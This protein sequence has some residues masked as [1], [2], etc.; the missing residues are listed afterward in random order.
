[1]EKQITEPQCFGKLKKT[2]DLLK[3]EKTLM[4]SKKRM[5]KQVAEPQCFGKLTKTQ[6]LLKI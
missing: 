3:R 2:Q 4:M 6:D 5:E 1:M